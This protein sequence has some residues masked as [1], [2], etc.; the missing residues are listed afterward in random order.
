MIEDDKKM[1]RHLILIFFLCQDQVK[2][3]PSV[4]A[5]VLGI[6]DVE[7]SCSDE[8]TVREKFVSLV[9]SVAVSIICGSEKPK[10]KKRILSQI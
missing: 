5:D 9:A 8:K 7:T 4:L 3:L 2:N 1:T 6:I 10:L